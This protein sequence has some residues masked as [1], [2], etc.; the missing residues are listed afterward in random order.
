M[1]ARALAVVALAS[2]VAMGCAASDLKSRKDNA[3]S[4]V[5]Q[6]IPDSPEVV[7]GLGTIMGAPEPTWVRYDPVPNGYGHPL[8]GPAFVLHPLG[9]ALDYALIR[10]FYLLGGLAP[11]W[12]GLS[13]EDAS[14]YHE[15]MP[16]L[17]NSRDAS[18]RFP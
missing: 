8:R 6:S 10:P 2:V 1:R 11:E 4:S 17:T 3:W 14:R 13:A 15:H 5:P 9:V 18:R 16:E 7:N 12:F